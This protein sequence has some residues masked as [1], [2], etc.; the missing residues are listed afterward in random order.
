MYLSRSVSD[1]KSDPSSFLMVARDS[2][3]FDTLANVKNRGV[4]FS[5][6]IISKFLKFSIS[7]RISASK[8]R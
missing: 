6:F 2:V 1:S 8:E 7:E 5:A 3:F 4:I